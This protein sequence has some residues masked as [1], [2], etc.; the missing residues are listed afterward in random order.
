MKSVAFFLCVAVFFL[1]PSACEASEAGIVKKGNQLY[2][3]GDYKAAL[4][5]YQK[6]LNQNP[7]SDIINF[8][9]GTAFYQQGD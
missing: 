3:K 2:N 4:E 5:N 8:N 1:M 7:D 9:V 6:A